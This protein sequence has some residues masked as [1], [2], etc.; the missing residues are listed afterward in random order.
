MEDE[1]RTTTGMKTNSK[2]CFKYTRSWKPGSQETG[3]LD[4]KDMKFLKKNWEIAEN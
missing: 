3:A 4:Y 1:E 2:M